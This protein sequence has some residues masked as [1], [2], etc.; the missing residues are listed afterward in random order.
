MLV[1][2]GL[3]VTDA[4]LEAARGH[5]DKVERTLVT[6]SPA[7]DEALGRDPASQHLR[8][9][10]IGLERANSY[11]RAAQQTI[12]DVA[13]DVA[14]GEAT[15]MGD[16]LR[17][18]ER[19]CAVADELSGYAARHLAAMSPDLGSPGAQDRDVSGALS[20]IGQV[21]SSAQAAGRLAA[22]LAV[23]RRSTP[24]DEAEPVTQRLRAEQQGRRM[25][26]VPAGAIGM[27]R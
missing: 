19:L 13:D 7:S 23:A 26:S 12:G 2:D 10:S 16:D 5:L 8:P 4:H 17:L 18:L 21:R 1:E 22:E 11:L 9:A 3:V 20:R 6:P 27:S 25:A 24:P 15:R 14:Q